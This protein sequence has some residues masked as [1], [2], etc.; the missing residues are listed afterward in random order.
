MQIGTQFFGTSD[1]GGPSPDNP[2]GGAGWLD[3]GAPDTQSAAYHP[4]HLVAAALTQPVVYGPT[5]TLGLSAIAA[6]DAMA[7]AVG[8]RVNVAYVTRAHALVAAT[9]AGLQ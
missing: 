1:G 4:W 7:L 2:Q 9:V 8:D 6:Q 3:D 5:V